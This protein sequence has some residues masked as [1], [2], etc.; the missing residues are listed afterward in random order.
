[1]LGQDD[2]LLAAQSVSGG[3]FSP[4]TASRPTSA[5]SATSRT[6]SAAK[7]A[8]ASW[9]AAIAACIASSA[10]RTSGGVATSANGGRAS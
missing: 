10:A 1:V 6:G 2:E 9:L 4:A 7:A 5:C 3:T 8:R